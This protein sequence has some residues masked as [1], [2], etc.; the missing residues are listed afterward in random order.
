MTMRWFGQQPWG[1]IC[2][3]S[4]RIPAPVDSPCGNCNASI[5]GDDQGLSIPLSY[6]S[7]DEALYDALHTTERHRVNYHL[8]CFRR[9]TP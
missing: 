7:A 4:T 3:P 2:E 6:G 9:A 1:S 8:E 5:T